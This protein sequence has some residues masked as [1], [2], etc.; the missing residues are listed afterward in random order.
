MDELGRPYAKWIKPDTKKTNT[1]ST[2]LYEE[3][4]KKREKVKLIE[5]ESRMV[6]AR[7]YTVGK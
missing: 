6:V 4:K 7:G 1:V 2:H 5:R 3:A